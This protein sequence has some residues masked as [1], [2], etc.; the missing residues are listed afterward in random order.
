[1]TSRGSSL[2]Q[3]RDEHAGSRADGAD[4]RTGEFVE[5]VEEVV[6]AP[7]YL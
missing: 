6:L 3:G 1:M 5:G 4:G 7:A 2:D